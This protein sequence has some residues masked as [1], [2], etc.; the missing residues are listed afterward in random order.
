MI[1]SDVTLP[2]PEPKKPEHESVYLTIRDMILFGEFEPG[3]PVTI[4]G[5]KAKVNAGMTPVREAIRRLTA[6]GALDAS[7]NRRVCVPLISAAQLAEI[8]LAR[9]AIEPAL[10]RLAAQRMQPGLPQTLRNI[11][12][13]LDDCIAAGDTRGY[14]RHNF[15]FHFRLYE[16]A[17]AQILQKLAMSLWL[18]IAPSL[19][20]MSGR[21]G[22]T[23][24]PDMHREAIAALERGDADMVARVIEQDI[25]QGMTN[26]AETLSEPAFD[27]K[28]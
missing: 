22:T 5:L 21:V 14:L 24:L 19:R 25:L 2:K 10:A 8:Q 26:V 12:T 18:Q 16:A 1:K 7:G 11:D 23:N 17:N 13:R 9:T 27:Q 15:A 4:L 28:N 6:E 3:Q 20:I